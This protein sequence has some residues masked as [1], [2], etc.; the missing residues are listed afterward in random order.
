MILVKADTGDKSIVYSVSAE[1]LH[2]NQNSCEKSLLRRLNLQ[3]SE[4]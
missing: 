2:V 3:K 1:I 4:N